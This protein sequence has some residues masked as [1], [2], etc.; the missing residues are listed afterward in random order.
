MVREN[1]NCEGMEK[2][3]R[4][5]HNLIDFSKTL[6]YGKAWGFFESLLKIETI[7]KPL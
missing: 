4:N 3:H 5:F 2:A 1:L 7:V 6:A